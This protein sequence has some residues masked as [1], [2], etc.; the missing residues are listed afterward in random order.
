MEAHR[1][2]DSGHRAAHGHDPAGP[3]IRADSHQARLEAVAVLGEPVRRELY[4]AIRRSPVPLGRHELARTLRLPPSTVAFQ[5]GKLVDAG[6]LETEFRKLGDRSGPGSGRPTKLYRAARSEVA[7]AVP[8]RHY[9]LAAHLLAAAITET[10][11][12][13]V[14]VQQALQEAAFG[15]GTRLGKAAGNLVTVLTD[16][17][18]QPRPDG[19]DGYVLENC[20]FH[21]LA[22]AHTEIVCAMNGALLAGA[23]EGCGDTSHE[24]VPDPTGPFCCARIPAKVDITPQ[25]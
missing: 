17:G 12:S 7:A 21:R 24:V 15:A 16:N 19:K 8:D 4:D 3:E 6:L 18:F 1:L 5:L 2:G 22:R 20:P 11:S 9:D 14:G 25:P 13:G 10:A 23:L